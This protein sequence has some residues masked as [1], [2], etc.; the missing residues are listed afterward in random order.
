MAVVIIVVFSPVLIR[1]KRQK[2]ACCANDIISFSRCGKRLVTTIVLNDE[3]PNQEKSVDDGQ[4]DG[5]PNGYIAPYVH[6]NP[7][8]NKWQERIQDLNGGF[9]TVGQLVSFDNGR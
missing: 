5:E 9:L 3:N 1:N 4:T 7:D 2:A 6:G 8:G